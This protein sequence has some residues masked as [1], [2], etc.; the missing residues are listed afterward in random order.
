M[1]PHSWPCLRADGTRVPE[2]ALI[3]DHGRRHRVLIIPA[4][5][6]EANKLRRLTV[7]VM[8]R[9]DNSGCDTML[10]DL[11]GCNESLQELEN[12]A[13]DDWALAIEAAAQHFA[14]THVLA[15]RGGALL[16]PPRLPG[17][18]YAPVKG[19][20]ILRQLLRARVLSSREAGAEESVDA[21][22]ERGRSEVIELAGYRLSPEMLRQLQ[23]SRQRERPGVMVIE[24]EMIGGGPLWLRAEP[25][26]D[27]SQA[28]A[29]AA[30]VAVGLAQ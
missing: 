6:D 30:V 9:L 23:E 21:L 16:L 12:I 3:A 19:A 8:R 27:R 4:L 1:T 25:A 17:W 29:L 26:E 18:C 2:H 10:P 15:I 7:E 13:P 24:Q 14:A 28:D 20:T 5:F 22:L 11:P